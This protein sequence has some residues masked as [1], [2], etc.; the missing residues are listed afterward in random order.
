[1]RRARLDQADLARSLV[2]VHPDEAK[3][4]KAIAVPLN[5]HDGSARSSHV[6]L[7]KRTADRILNSVNIG[8]TADPLQRKSLI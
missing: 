6:V 4:W 2:W 7:V 1:M 8:Q 3:A 5:L